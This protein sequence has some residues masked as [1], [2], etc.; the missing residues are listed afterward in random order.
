[1][2]QGII[3]S[4]TDVMMDGDA[5]TEPGDIKV[6]KG[7]L[8]VLD[9]CDATTQWSVH[10]GAG[11]TIELDN[12]IVYE[13]TGSIKVTVP[14]STTAIIKATKAA[15]SW[16]LSSYN[17]LRV[18]LRRAQAGAMTAFFGEV[19]YNEQTSGSFGTIAA[20]SWF[21][22]SWDISGIAAAS[23]NGVTIFAVSMLNASATETRYFWIDYVFADPGPSAVR[24]FDGDRVINIYP[25]VYTS[26][27]PGT[28]V[29]KTITI[30]RKG[31][32]S[33]VIIQGAGHPSF[34]KTTSMGSTNSLELGAGAAFQTD[35][36]IALGDCSFG[37]DTHNDV[38]QDTHTYHY[39]AFWDD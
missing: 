27:Y 26:S 21:Q 39:M 1:M 14:P 5:P 15:G 12:T 8:L 32:P 19:A 28:G 38:N 29:A 16:D 13:G 30:P 35:R 10:S 36:I 37:I 3:P 34:W 23:R 2:V 25:K 4:S 7:A 24:A 11:V 17:Y 9:A 6:V 31:T 22:K 18:A 33:S 20:N